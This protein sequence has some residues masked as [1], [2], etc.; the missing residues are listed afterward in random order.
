MSTRDR[1][2]RH[3]RVKKTTLQAFTRN[4][5]TKKDSVEIEIPLFALKE[6]CKCGGTM[7]KP[8]GM[9]KLLGEWKICSKCSAEIRCMRKEY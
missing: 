6:R 8:A 9:P 3:W 2:G 5:R 7:M 1:L 4:P